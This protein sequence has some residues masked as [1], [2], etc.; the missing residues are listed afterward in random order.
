MT[1]VTRMTRVSEEWDRG[2]KKCK[3]VSMCHIVINKP[4]FITLFDDDT[5]MTHHDTSYIHVIILAIN[6]NHDISTV[7]LYDSTFGGQMEG[8]INTIFAKLLY[9]SHFFNHF[10]F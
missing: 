1:H 10:L 9:L 6:K 3:D 5:S 7:I 2:V 4:L 8:R